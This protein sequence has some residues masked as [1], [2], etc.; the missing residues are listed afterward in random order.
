MLSLLQKENQNYFLSTIHNSDFSSL[1]IYVIQFP[2][3]LKYLDLA[4]SKYSNNLWR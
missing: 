3:Y 4:I 1:I 2:W